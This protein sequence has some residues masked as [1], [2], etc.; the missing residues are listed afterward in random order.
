ME[1]T[2]EIIEY[3]GGNPANGDQLYEVVVQGPGGDFSFEFRT[4][5]LAAEVDLEQLSKMLF[6][7][8]GPDAT[9]N[10]KKRS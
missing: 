10:G 2:I 6:I 7:I 3:P 5:K 4:T 9:I 1:F 8:C